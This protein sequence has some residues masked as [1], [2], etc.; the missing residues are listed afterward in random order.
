MKR[1]HL[2]VVHLCETRFKTASYLKHLSKWTYCTCKQK[3][4]NIYF[5]GVN[6]TRDAVLWLVYENTLIILYWLGYSLHY[7]SLLDNEIPL[8][9]TLEIIWSV[10]VG[11]GYSE[12]HMQ[13]ENVLRDRIGVLIRWFE[14]SAYLKCGGYNCFNAMDFG[15]WQILPNGWVFAII[16]NK[17]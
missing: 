12:L 3:E 15:L 5:L 8:E 11:G 7:V 13:L 6:I 16:N 4:F 9:I 17:G 2:G 1:R 14:L 10:F